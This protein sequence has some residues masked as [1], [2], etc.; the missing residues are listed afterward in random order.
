ME[1]SVYGPVKAWNTP[2]M[3]Q[4]QHTTNILNMEEGDP[5]K[6]HWFRHTNTGIESFS[7]DS[8]RSKKK[9]SFNMITM[10]FRTLKLE[11]T[12]KHEFGLEERLQLT[13]VLK[14]ILHYGEI[15]AIEL[16]AS[17]Y[18]RAKNLKLVLS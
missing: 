9:S 17:M 12:L 14:H 4:N 2:I 15:N 10:H 7:I 11:L 1:A 3:L 8:G 18:R 16:E 6:V 13:L 5:K